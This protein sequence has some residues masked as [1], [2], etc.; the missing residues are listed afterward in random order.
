MTTNKKKSTMK[1]GQE[2]NGKVI[3]TMEQAIE[4]LKT[5]QP[6]FYRWLREGKLKGMKVGRQWRFYKEDIEAFMRGDSPNVEIPPEINNLQEN[7]LMRIREFNNDY[8]YDENADPL[9]VVFDMMVYLGYKMRA[10]DIHLEVFKDE[11]ILRYRIDGVL[12]KI[13]DSI[14]KSLL[15]F[16]V[17]QWK[18]EAKCNVQKSELSQD[19]KITIEVEGKKLIIFVHIQPTVFGESVIARFIDEVKMT[20]SL[21]TLLIDDENLKIIKK[22]LDKPYGLFLCTGPTGS[23]KTTT[24]YSALNY[25]N[26]PGRKLL[27]VEDP[28]EYYHNFVSQ[29]AIDE[30]KGIT[31][32]SVIKSFL[33]CDPD[34][35]MVGEIRNLETAHLCHTAALTG[36]IVLTQLHTIDSVSALTRLVDVGVPPYLVGDAVNLIIAQRLIRRICTHCAIEAELTTEQIEEAKSRVSNGGMDWMSLPKKWVKSVGCPECRQL[37]YRGRSC[38][39]ELL[40]M[41]SEIRSALI[42]GASESELRAIAIDQGMITLSAE[43][44]R[45]ASEGETTMEEA[46]RISPPE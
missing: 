3:L 44:I 18:S 16:L 5:S 8:N 41:T 6:T 4:F 43:A 1:D 27:S 38:I 19:G 46:L 31:F 12:H 23:G 24:L 36:H 10:S 35:I 26:K 2:S 13:G 11:V 20:F 22:S 42:R 21:D 34:V 32:P 33:R 17:D 30:G 29:V 37:G 7:L 28:V 39:V 9:K 15:P 14:P 25:V 40:V 45:R